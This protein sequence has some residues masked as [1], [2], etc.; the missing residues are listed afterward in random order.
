[1]LAKTVRYLLKALGV[2]LILLV[3]GIGLRLG[4]FFYRNNLPFGKMQSESSAGQLVSYVNPF[5]GTGGFSQVS[6]HNFPG[7]S[8]P[9]GMVRLSPDTYSTVFRKKALNTSGY[10]Y[11]DNRIMGFSHTRLVGTGA[12][13]GGHIRVIPATSG[14]AWGK[15]ISGRYTRFRHRD[16]SARPGYY[17]VRMGKP[18]IL[19][20]LTATLRTG[21]HRYTFPDGAEP[22]ILMDICSTL[23]YE[24]AD[25]GRVAIFPELGV[26]EGEVKT[27]GRFAGR[28]GGIKVYFHARF[29][30]PVDRVE[31]RNGP[32][33]IKDQ[34]SGEGTAL[35]VACHF[36]SSAGQQ[37]IGLRIGL[38]HVSL[39]NAR[40][41]LEHETSGK[42][43]EDIVAEASA[44]W[45][46]RMNLIRVESD[47]DTEKT[48]FYTAMYRAFQ[49]PTIFQDVNGEYTGFDKQVHTA[50]GFS[51]YTDM[52]LWDTFRTV[53]PLYTLI[54]PGEQR[55]M[56]V[57][58]VKMRKQGGWLPRWPSGYGYTNSMLGSPADILISESYQKGIRDYDIL[59][60]YESMKEVA[61][62][63]VP[64]G[65]PFSGR[66][67]IGDCREY[68]YCPSDKMS[69][70]VSRTLEYAW[71][72][73]AIAIL[74]DSLGFSGDAALFSQLAG[75]YR[76]TWNPATKYFQPRDSEGKFFEHFRPRLLT[77]IDEKKKYTDDYV[78]GCALQWRYAVPFDPQGLISLFGG[79][80]PFAE[81]LTLFFSKA[82]S[83]LGRLYPG[84]YYW[85]GNQPYIHSA[86]LFNEAQRPDLT[87]KWVRWILDNKYGATATGL[88]GN[89]DG[90]TLSAWYIFSSIGLYP[91]AG[92]D[93]YQVGSPLFREASIRV[94]DRTL[95]MIA[96]NH[97]PGNIYVSRVTLNGKP[98]EGWKVRHKELTEGGILRFE[99][100]SA[101]PAGLP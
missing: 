14:H 32:D 5:I 66:R 2:M 60:A 73:H 15:Y 41:N 43:F 101:P 40:M 83:Y 67:G 46:E 75:H 69:Q 26:V 25:T 29:D 97:S 96:G 63:P 100:S 11:P 35:G 51:Y 94:G 88:D 16:E 12:I 56:I 20:E 42:S 39:E 18:S 81:A 50:E 65:S 36:N 57:S 95:R 31:I 85:H 21:F 24:R 53:H 71:A 77:Y 90:G 48:I 9:Y 79:N 13:D 89:D 52:S 58:L 55:D 44:Q 91:V 10:F 76:N 59:S 54:V 6:P 45:E 72:D 37:V 92:T 8:V 27:F 33:L 19:A 78:E 38:S 82:N 93:Y 70:S 3:L 30:R 4:Y 64:Q 28:F 80:E 47:C 17:G 23:G 98:V 68:G 87:Q 86:Y 22:H 49:M 61:L 84:S 34:N 7:A 62:H 1:M 99:M 74:A